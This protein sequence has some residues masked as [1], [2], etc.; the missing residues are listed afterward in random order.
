M[1]TKCTYFQM[2]LSCSINR[3]RNI[4]YFVITLG[5]MTRDKLL[6]DMSP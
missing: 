2:T 6:C 5:Y 3:Q 1:Q 4:P